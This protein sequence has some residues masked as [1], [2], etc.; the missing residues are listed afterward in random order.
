[1]QE[2]LLRF[3]VVIQ[4][5]G[6][7]ETGV[8]AITVFAETINGADP[9]ADSGDSTVPVPVLRLTTKDSITLLYSDTFAERS[10]EIRSAIER[11]LSAAVSRFAEGLA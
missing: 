4:K 8:L 7:G 6:R 10:N 1:V 11:T 2:I 5:V 3:A 9:D